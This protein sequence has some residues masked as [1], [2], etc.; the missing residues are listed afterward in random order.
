MT[1]KTLSDNNADE[2][3]LDEVLV[4]AIALSLAVFICC[5]LW[6]LYRRSKRSEASSL[7]YASSVKKEFDL[8]DTLSEKISSDLSSDRLL[9]G[10]MRLILNTN[11][12]FFVFPLGDF[13]LVCRFPAPQQAEQLEIEL[14]KLGIRLKIIDVNAGGDIDHEAST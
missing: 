13:A 1:A 7:R 11:V 5:M 10:S 6:F 8:A 12:T 14:K 4:I 9:F 2:T 3:D